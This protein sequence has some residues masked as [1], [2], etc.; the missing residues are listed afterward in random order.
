MNFFHTEAGTIYYISFYW[1]PNVQ[2]STTTNGTWRWSLLS[3]SSSWIAGCSCDRLTVENW[4]LF[5]ISKKTI[6]FP[7]PFT[8]AFPSPSYY[9]ACLVPAR[10]QSSTSG[11]R[12]PISY[13]GTACSGY[14]YLRRAWPFLPSLGTCLPSTR[15]LIDIYRCNPLPNVECERKQGSSGSCHNSSF[16]LPFFPF[17]L[18]SRGFWS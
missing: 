16:F 14:G 18:T 10:S 1:G 5:N 8:R 11:Q 17:P 3:T 13:R 15:I 4:D 6:N 12:D 9:R 2:Y 7:L